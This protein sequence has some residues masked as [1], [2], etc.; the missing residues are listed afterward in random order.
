MD[1]AKDVTT[2]LSTLVPLKL[3]DGSSL[4]DSTEYQQVIGALEYLSLTRPDISF[5]INKI[6]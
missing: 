2:P 6:S 3:V 1:S 5:T 4:V